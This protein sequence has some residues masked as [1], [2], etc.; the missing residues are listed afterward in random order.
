MKW[1]QPE[2]PIW[3]KNLVAHGLDVGDPSLLVP[4]DF[5][6]LTES[7]R[8]ST[9]LEDFGPD[10]Q[11]RPHLERLIEAI[12][13]EANLHV[14]G[15]LVTA[16]ELLW[17]LQNRLKLTDL[18]RRRPEVLETPIEQP[19]FV[20]GSARSGTSITH[21]LFGCDPAV[22]AP[23]L[24]EML[25]P[26]ERCEE[27]PDSPAAEAGGLC[28]EFWHQLQP[29]YET[30]H[31]NAGDLPNECIHIFM[32][33]FL[34]DQLGGPHQIRSFD[35][36]MRKTDPHI[37]YAEHRRV[38]QTL[39]PGT[40]S[41]RWVLKAPSHLFML[42][43]LFDV[44]PDARVVVT[45][46]DPITCI[47]STVSLLGTIKAM[48]ADDVDLE[49]T[50]K[51]TLEGQVWQW[52]QFMEARE[53]GA[54]PDDQFVDVR[55]ADLVSDPANTLEAV[56]AELGWNMDQEKKQA[57]VDYIAHKPKGSRGRHDYSPELFGIDVA[58]ERP[59]FEKYQERF[60]VPSEFE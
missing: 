12:D 15:R 14:L 2:R 44:Y 22:R 6:H 34:S 28:Y 16:T 10:E 42:R 52:E 36:Y 40:K 37:V 39:E 17:S 32:L 55:Y 41:A 53:C 60:G 18:W 45:H 46:R 3:A 43:A 49:P 25:H 20:T 57:I 19:V 27:G 54:L 5:E 9:G 48:R 24:W 33:N 51:G 50:A 29:E 58:R 8:A 1:T 7:A 30:M 47:A 56:Y 21:E 59:R 23:L 35:A 26:A 11:W 4:I 31:V 38:L 13:E